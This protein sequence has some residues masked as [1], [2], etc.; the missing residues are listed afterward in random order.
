MIPSIKILTSDVARVQAIL[1][2]SKTEMNGAIRK[3]LKAE[4]EHL[5][6]KLVESVDKVKPPLG[7]PRLNHGGSKPLRKTGELV[8]SIAAVVKNLELFVGIPR[9][10]GRARL[11]AIHENGAVI[12]QRMT[13]RQRKFLHARLS[14]IASKVGTGGGSGNGILV[15][16]IPP[17]PFI[18]PVLEAEESQIPQRFL[19]RVV[20]NL[21]GKMGTP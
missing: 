13:D 21:G 16:V 10:S 7:W 8:N 19:D 12:V 15:I 14:K 2:A 20:T 17:R 3:A 6:A 9:A 4:G 11:A 18:R 5:R 1:N